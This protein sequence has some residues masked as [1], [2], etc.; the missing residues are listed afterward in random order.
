[1]ARRLLKR[2]PHGLVVARFYLPINWC[3]REERA[4]V[5]P[6]RLQRPDALGWLAAL[7][8]N[9]AED[10]DELSLVALS[11]PLPLRGRQPVRQGDDLAQAI[12]RSV[13]IEHR[14]QSRSPALWHAGVD[15]GNAPLGV[16]PV[17]AVV[18]RS[19]GLAFGVRLRARPLGELPHVVQQPGQRR[20]VHVL[21]IRHLRIRH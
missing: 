20:Q 18:L 21:A 14:R 11:G 15:E 9:L 8:T 2:I 17:S 7:I 19:K 10:R 12:L 16:S 6:Q 4:F 3:D 1:M 13:V 5:Q